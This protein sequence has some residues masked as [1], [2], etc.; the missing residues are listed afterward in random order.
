MLQQRTRAW[1]SLLATSRTC[2]F[3]LK[4][5]APSLPQL[6]VNMWGT[7]QVAT[8]CKKLLVLR[9]QK[10]RDV[11]QEIQKDTSAVKISTQLTLDDFKNYNF[12]AL[13]RNKTVWVLRIIGGVIILFALLALFSEAPSMTDIFTSLVMGLI[14]VSLSPLMIILFAKRNFS[15]NKELSEPIAYEFDEHSVS[16]ASAYAQTKTPWANLFKVAVSKN[17]L[18]LYRSRQVANIIPVRYFTQQQID[19]IKQFV[20][21]NKVKANFKK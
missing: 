13:Y 10:K 16:S 20:L 17:W 6:C 3:G 9:E 11:E 12:Y 4:H 2:H 19:K 5:A 1:L 14:L 21:L 18:I 15:S 8:S 7:T